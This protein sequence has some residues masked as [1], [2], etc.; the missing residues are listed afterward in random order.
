[1]QAAVTELATIAGVDLDTAARALAEALVLAA[2]GTTDTVLV[3]PATYINRDDGV[4]LV[5]LPMMVARRERTPPR[6][7]VAHHLAVDP[8]AACTR[9]CRDAIV[10][11]LAR[12][13]VDVRTYTSMR[14]LLAAAHAPDKDETTH[15]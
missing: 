5:Q 14:A 1:M 10:K 7:F 6:L 3:G 8:A 4:H 15:H 2:G 9:L 13:F 11:A 12:S